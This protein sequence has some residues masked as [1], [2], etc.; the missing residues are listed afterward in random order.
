MERKKYREAFKREA[1]RKMELRGD[2]TVAEV[3]KDLGVR[4]KLLYTWRKHLNDVVEDIRTERGETLEQEVKRLRKE[5]R[6][7]KEER[8]V[9]KKSVAFFVKESD[10]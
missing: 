4:T 7:L 3:A 10:R 1:V 9:L 5:N 6:E 8:N 2:R